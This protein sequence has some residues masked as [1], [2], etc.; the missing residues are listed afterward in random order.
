MYHFHLQFAYPWAPWLFLLLIPALGITLFLYFRM[1]KR[2]RRTRNRV[3]SIILHMLVMTLCITVLTGLV[4]VYDVANDEN[5]IILLV[6]VSDTEEESADARDDFVERVIDD[7]GLDGFKVGVVTFGFTQEYA[8]PL[9]YDTDEAYASY[10]AAPLPDTSATDVAAALRFT[11]TL[12]TNPQTSKIV[13]VTDGKETDENAANVISSIVAQGTKVD[14]VYISS[15][16]SKD[17]VRVTGVEFPDYHIKVDEDCAITVMLESR[18]MQS[19]TVELLDNGAAL[20]SETRDLAEGAQSVSFTVAF[21]EGGLHEIGVRISSLGDTFEENNSF[22]S[23]Y[24]LEVFNKVLVL[25][26]FDGDS[27]EIEKLLSAEGTD[28]EATYMNV[29][30]E[31]MPKSVEELRSYDQVVLNNVANA[32][33]PEGFADVLYSYVYDWGGGLLT[34][35]GSDPETEMAHAY[36]R[37]DL[38]NTRLQQM[39]PVQAINYTPPVGVVVIIDISGSMDSEMGELTMREWAVE[40]AYECLNALTERDFFGIMTLDTTY[41]T[42]LPLTRCSQQTTIRESLEQIKTFQGGMTNY[43]NALDV[44]GQA[45]VALKNV[46]RRHIILVTDGM[47]GDE[48]RDY[49]PIVREYYDNHEITV[50]TV[51]LGMVEGETR[52]NV[53]QS[54][55]DAAHGRAHIFTFSNRD[56]LLEEMREDLNAKEIKEVIP[57]PFHPRV[58]NVLSPVMKGVE[59]GAAT[60]ESDNRRLFA[61]QLGGFYGVRVRTNADL[62][63]VGDYDVP[64]Y[65]QWK[66][67][68]GM[69]GSFM[70][71][72]N[73]TWSS[74]FLGDANGQRFLYNVVDNLMPTS[75]IR[76]GEISAT[77]R[78]GNYI[79]QLSVSADLKDGETI[80]ARIE[81][82]AE[83]DNF[84]LNLNEI[85]E[86]RNETTETAYVTTA[87]SAQNGYSRCTFVL[88]NKGVY[89]IVIEK[90]NA[91]GEVTASYALYK[92]FAYSVEYGDYRQDENILAQNLKRLA[93]DSGGTLIA[94]N[95]DPYEIFE[96]FD[97]YITKEFDPRILFIS[98]AMVLFLLDIVVRKFRF[99]WIHEIVRERRENKAQE[100]HK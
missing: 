89:R 11:R 40:G 8:V 20:A 43:A 71:D 88:K 74:E 42:V 78:E 91:A 22:T 1:N 18:A 60:E 61:A 55:A 17:T 73:G 25:N 29:G 24:Y 96:N 58:E 92:S 30:D 93:S 4:F 87:L 21:S 12:F 23:Y 41:S 45:L 75:N 19:V 37:Q 90:C 62:I 47:P 79:N 69:V 10:L 98:I 39:L 84:V 14:S 49:M 53:L 77:L 36:N 51:G 99:K 27:A 95:E 59:T 33:L 82:T 7:C 15:D 31:G 80:R 66:F 85:D 70:S 97:I 48:E 28:Y 57:E 100:E 6:D 38:Y 5:E 32:D 86:E 35:G 9:T 3:I 13:L 65:A 44:A 16:F 34:V 50:S 72:L 52:A 46:D 81:G 68:K 64:L 76:L 26:Y 83:G 2:Y 54:I 67:G 94:D 63:L 56:K